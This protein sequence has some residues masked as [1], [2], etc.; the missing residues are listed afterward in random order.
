VAR[1][2][3]VEPRPSASPAN[4]G[5]GPLGLPFT[6]LVR[7]ALGSAD[8]ET[9]DCHRL[10]QEGVS[11]LL[12]VE[13]SG[14]PRPPCVPHEVRDLTRQISLANPLWSARAKSGLPS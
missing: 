11:A 2:T 5:P 12:G 3:A 1:A 14:P 13:E 8:R 10:A 9:R 4:L 7:L 6:A